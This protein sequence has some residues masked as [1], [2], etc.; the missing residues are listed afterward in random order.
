[1]Y[2]DD[3]DRNGIPDA[4]QRDP[5]VAPP[6]PFG[7]FD[8][9][10]DPGLPGITAPVEATSEPQ[11]EP[12]AGTTEQ[13]GNESQALGALSNATSEV[14]KSIGDGLNSVARK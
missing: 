3:I 7:V 10:P 6:V 11:P 13:Q 12:A 9:D 8:P 5:V 14:L 1:M 4:I 2:D